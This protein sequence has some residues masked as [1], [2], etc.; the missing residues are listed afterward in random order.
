M[1]LNSLSPIFEA[2]EI[3]KYILSLDVVITNDRES[4]LS[5]DFG[6]VLSDE[7]L[8]GLAK[9]LNGRIYNP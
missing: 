2:L 5:N 7:L 8:M 9:I 6:Y 4:T 1:C 3:N